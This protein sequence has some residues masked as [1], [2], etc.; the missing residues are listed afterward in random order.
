MKLEFVTHCYACE[1]PHYASALYTQLASICNNA[2]NKH[3]SKCTVF[4]YGGDEHVCE[5][6]KLFEDEE[7]H[8]RRVEKIDA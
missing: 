6:L 3:K 5:V 4:Y 1:M 8:V 2:S 7:R